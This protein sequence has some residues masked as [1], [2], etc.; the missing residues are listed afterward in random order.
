[1]S[2]Y[3]PIPPLVNSDG[4]T[5]EVFIIAEIGINHNGDLKIAKQLID[6][7]KAAGCDAVKFQKRTIDVVY[8][9]DVL[10]QPRESPWGSTQRD[11]KMG[12]EFGVAEYDE[13]N[14]YCNEVGI[15]WFASA[16][17]I[18]SQNF[19]R[20]YN[21]PYNKVASAMTTHVAF[22]GE[23]ASEKKMTFISTGMCTLDDVDHAVKIFRDADC[24]FVLLHTVSTYPAKESDL[25]LAVMATLRERYECPV[26]Y[27]GH[28]PSVSPSVIAGALGAQVIERHVT[29]ERSMYGSDQSA[30]LEPAGLLN[31]VSTIRKISECVGNGEKQVIDAEK[32][33]AKKLRYWE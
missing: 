1:M 13:I 33:V 28:E 9:P 31:L 21:C 22:L 23:V 5:P 7:S 12:L 17:D 8:S 2:I 14:R 10:D 11:Q 3:K 32:E 15:I 4:K 27:S 19:L 26:G 24:P 18:P 16:W 25:N 20:Q 6:Q 29:L 30:S